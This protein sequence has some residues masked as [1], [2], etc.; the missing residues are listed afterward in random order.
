MSPVFRRDPAGHD[1]AQ[2]LAA[3]RI[4]EPLEAADAV[5][6]DAHL[7]GCDACAAAADAFDADRDLF[8][9]LRDAPPTP[10]RDLWARTAAAIDAESAG[11]RTRPGWRILGVP[12]LTLAPVAGLAA[13]AIVVGAGLL[14]GS[15]IVPGPGG[16]SGPAPTPIALAP[17]DVAVL[18]RGADGSYQVERGVVD[19]VCPLVA[20]TC[21]ASPSFEATQLARIDGTGSVGAIISP[22]KDRLVVVQRGASGVDGVYVVPVKP[23]G[24]GTTAATAAPSEAPATVVPVTAPPVTAPPASVDPSTEPGQSGDPVEPTPAVTPSPDPSAEAPSASTGPAQ[25]PSAEPPATPEASAEPSPQ[26]TPTVAVTAAPEGGDAIQIARDVV[27]VGG[28]ATYDADGSRFAFTARPADGSTGPDVYVWDTT[29]PLARAVTTDHGSIFAG[30]DGRDLLVSRVVDGTPQTLHL[31]AR[32][33][34]EKDTPGRAAWLPTLAPDRARA[35]WWNGSVDLAD[36]DLT[37]V[38]EKGRL[39]LGEWPTGGDEQVLAKGALT[40][41]EVRWNASGTVVGVWTTTDAGAGA[42]RLSL[43]PV[44]PATGRA[45]LDAPILDEA[46]AFAG[47]AMEDGRAVYPGP[48][49]D[50]ERSL[51]VVAWNDGLVVGRVELDGEDGATVIR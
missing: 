38:P 11:R 17:G 27:V 32:T 10:P 28:I 40:S 8:G 47:F 12:A 36:D 48:G 19:E 37:W 21:G 9:A 50:G 20:E 23:G 45:R 49:S 41:W 26:P 24:G 18:T 43:Y 30:W 15:P 51:W 25:S 29:E 46:P 16:A 6:L 35:A 14:N 22:A 2:E 13:V 3:T 5:W 42:G 39:V 33:G 4:D 1:R 7:A 44:D 31:D 34:A